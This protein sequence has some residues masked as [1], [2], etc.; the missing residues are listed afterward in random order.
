MEARRVWDAE[1]GG[2]SPPT[3]TVVYITPKLREG[4]VRGVRTSSKTWKKV[5]VL[6]IAARRNE[7]GRIQMVQVCKRDGPIWH[8]V[9]I[10]DREGLVR[11]LRDGIGVYAGTPMGIEGDFEILGPVS[12]LEGR[13]ILALDESALQDELPVPQF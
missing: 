11:I 8:D 9:R 1:V 13:G 10:L 6:V 12:F 2:S 4:A 7:Y 5:D 3:P